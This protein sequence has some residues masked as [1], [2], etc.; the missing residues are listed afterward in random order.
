MAETRK[1]PLFEHADR[2][3]PDR[4]QRAHETWRQCLGTDCQWYESKWGD[5]TVKVLTAVVVDL[6]EHTRR[7][8]E[9]TLSH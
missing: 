7:L 3:Q 9:K 1:C 4:P 2:T 8:I 5:C 6:C